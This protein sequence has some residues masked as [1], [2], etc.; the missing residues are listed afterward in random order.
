MGLVELGPYRKGGPVRPDNRRSRY[1]D[2]GVSVTTKARKKCRVCGFKIRGLIVNHE[3][4]RHHKG[5][6]EWSQWPHKA[7]RRR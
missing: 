4:G 7:G 1:G 2:E 3:E 5:I 6:D